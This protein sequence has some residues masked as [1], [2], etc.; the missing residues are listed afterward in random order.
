MKVVDGLI[1]AAR[2]DRLYMPHSFSNR[3][4]S[5]HTYQVGFTDHYF[6]AFD[7]HI[8]QTTNHSTHW[9]FNVKLLQ[10]SVGRRFEVFCGPWRGRKRDFRCLSQWCEVGKAHIRLVCRQ[11]TSLSIQVKQAI[12]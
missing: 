6:V 1:S 7:Y 10:D 2:L 8:L 11:Y 5:S 3:L 4:L 12:E 9:H